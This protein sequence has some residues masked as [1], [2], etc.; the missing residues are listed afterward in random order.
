MTSWGTLDLYGTPRHTTV[1][2][3]TSVD[4]WDRQFLNLLVLAAIDGSDFA[5]VF[6]CETK[7]LRSIAL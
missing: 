5:C 2:T 7:V 1:L 6:S 4:S 3:W